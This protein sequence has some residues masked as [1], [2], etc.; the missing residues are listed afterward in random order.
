[1]HQLDKTD[2][3]NAWSVIPLEQ[4]SSA[5]ISSTDKSHSITAIYLVEQPV[6]DEESSAMLVP[7]MCLDSQGSLFLV[8]PTEDST[9]QTIIFNLAVPFPLDKHRLTVL[10][11]SS[12]TESGALVFATGQASIYICRLSG[13]LKQA[14]LRPRLVDSS[15]DEATR[16][17]LVM[18]LPLTRAILSDSPVLAIAASVPPYPQKVSDFLDTRLLFVS[19]VADVKVYVI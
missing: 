2:T 6:P 12:R 1:V 13:I 9:T 16:N 15:Q 5:P 14:K 4:P 8:T 17:E 11:L 10:P 7:F 3:T 19:T 18:Q